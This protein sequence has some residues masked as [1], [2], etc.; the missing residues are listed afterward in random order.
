MA[1][2]RSRQRIA[3]E[4]TIHDHLPVRQPTTVDRSFELPAGLW[5]ATAGA[6]FGFI[7]VMA[8]GFGSPGL[9]VPMAIF[10][11]FFG[12]FFGVPA[13][14]MRMNP[15]N[16]QRLTP[17]GRFRESGVMTAY[18]RMTANAAIVQMLLLPVLILGWSLMVVTIA[19]VV[20]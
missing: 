20:R 10:I 4:A 5:I 16:P 2:K 6:Y 8:L 12:M 17:W 9:I 13:L 3:A 15:R 11:V 18:G 19:A 7:G 14:W 1:Q